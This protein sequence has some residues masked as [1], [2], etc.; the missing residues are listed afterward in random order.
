MSASSSISPWQAH[1]LAFPGSG[2]LCHGR[3]PP[4]AA[5]PGCIW[6]GLPHS[7]LT[8][9]GPAVPTRRGRVRGPGG[10]HRGILLIPTLN[11][12]MPKRVIVERPAGAQGVPVDLAWGEEVMRG[13]ARRFAPHLIVAR[14]LPAATPADIWSARPCFI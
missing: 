14:M 13:A 6:P 12:S 3:P 1:L 7:V 9:P 5:G 10:G 11:N 8:R 4:A 2:R